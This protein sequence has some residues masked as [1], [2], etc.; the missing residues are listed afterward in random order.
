M[1]RSKY[2]ERVAP[3]LDLILGWARDGLT[4]DDIAKNLNIT[5]Q[6]LSKYA[7]E[8]NKDGSFKHALLHQY[9]K[10]GRELA[11]YRVE[12]ALYKAATGYYSIEKKYIK[13]QD[14][15]EEVEVEVYHPPSVAALIFWLKNRKPDT[16]KDKIAEQEIAEEITDI[17]KITQK[18]VR[19]EAEKTA[20]G[21]ATTTKTGSI[22]SEA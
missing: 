14:G 7:S 10:E 22:S 8:K 15:I 17:L 20:G 1:A 4:L 18:E 16:W 12:N 13:T 5:R 9:L 6:T 21:M 19:D 2:E 3:K 11:D